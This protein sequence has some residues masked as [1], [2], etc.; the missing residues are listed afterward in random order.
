MARS[1]EDIDSMPAFFDDIRVGFLSDFF[2]AKCL[3]LLIHIFWVVCHRI[4]VLASSRMVLGVGFP[5]VAIHKCIL[6]LQGFSCVVHESWRSLRL[7]Y[8]NHD[9]CLWN[10]V[11]CLLFLFKVHVYMTHCRKCFLFLNYRC[12]DSVL[13][14]D[15]VIP[16]WCFHMVSINGI[17]CM[18]L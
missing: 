7:L 14:R 10:S 1:R 5:L 12:L 3:Y 16:S 8:G 4:L 9:D 2:N 18:W 13:F 15:E 17:I 11:G 6:V